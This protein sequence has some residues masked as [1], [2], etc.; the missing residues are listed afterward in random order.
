MAAGLWRKGCPEIRGQLRRVEM[1]YWDFDGKVSR[2]V[3][4]VNQDITAS[5]TRIFTRLFEERFPIRRM[6]PMEDYDGDLNASLKDDN[7]SA[8]NCRRANQINAPF[9]ESPHANGR[10]IDI[11]PYENPWKDLRTKQWSPSAEFAARTPGKGKINKGGLVWQA[12][13]DEGWVWQDIKVAD[14]MHFDTGYPSAPFTGRPSG[15]VGPSRGAASP[16]ATG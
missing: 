12:F 16:S 5:V 11:N 8:Y 13:I 6:Q 1:N 14:Y 10:A 15:S 4:V 2:G 7:T 9:M 3:L